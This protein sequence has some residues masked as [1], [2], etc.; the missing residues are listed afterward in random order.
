MNTRPLLA[1]I[2]GP[3]LALATSAPHLDAATVLGQVP[4]DP[5]FFS[6]LPPTEPAILG[7]NSLDVHVNAP[8]YPEVNF[9][10]VPIAVPGF[11]GWEALPS[12]P[13]GG[14]LFVPLD[15]SAGRYI[16]AFVDVGLSLEV[17]WNALHASFEG[18]AGSVSIAVD[19]T[20][21]QAGGGDTLVQ[22]QGP[23]VD[24]RVK[25]VPRLDGKVGFR[26][27]VDHPAECSV[28]F[29][30]FFTQTVTYAAGG[31][32]VLQLPGTVGGTGNNGEPTDNTGQRT[33]SDSCQKP[34]PLDGKYPAQAPVPNPGTNPPTSTTAMEDGPKLSRDPITGEELHQW[35][36]R[37]NG[38]VVTKIHVRYR[39]TTYVV[40]TC[41]GSAPD[42]VGIVEWSHDRTYLY[43]PPAGGQPGAELGGPCPMPGGTSGFP[44][45]SPVI[46]VGSGQSMAPDHKDALDKYKAGT[47]D[48]APR[49]PGAW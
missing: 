44:N 3:I 12:T 28:A 20:A 46:H 16:M 15:E 25:E 1:A 11:P 29:Y 2:A 24:I 31:A 23:C 49:Q 14:V 8:G 10:G 18:T 37:M 17:D 5:V 34:V 36:T 32:C 40:L 30:Q 22:G 45:S 39:F 6:S 13:F 9:S 35:I 33:Y 47:Y 42:I 21:L 43:P 7:W 27:E 4:P 41:P 38:D 19:P 26:I 48:G